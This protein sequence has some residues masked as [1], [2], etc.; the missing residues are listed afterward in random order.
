MPCCAIMD[1]MG[2]TMAITEG[3]IMAGIMVI[4]S[5]DMV[6]VILR[7]N[8][9]KYYVQQVDQKALVWVDIIIIDRLITGLSGCCASWYRDFCK[10]VT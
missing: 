5:G 6:V 7:A 4:T 1:I 8:T 3:A 10:D 9:T 2:G